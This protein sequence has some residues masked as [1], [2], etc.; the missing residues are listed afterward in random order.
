MKKIFALILLL[1]GLVM[2]QVQTPLLP[3]DA[4]YKTSPYMMYNDNGTAKY[5]VPSFKH[6]T[7]YS[8]YLAI[9]DTLS[10]DTIQVA[11]SDTTTVDSV[12]VT[13]SDT[14]KFNFNRQ[15]LNGFISLADSNDSATDTLQIFHRSPFTNKLTS[16][17]VALK[18]MLTGNL[19]SDN[20]VI[21]PGQG[22]EK[23][24]KINI[25]YPGE[26]YITWKTKSGKA[27]RRIKTSFLGIGY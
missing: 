11:D 25:E 10:I 18:E 22:K 14:V 1:S 20:T 19:V 21:I 9:A 4:N 17:M 3:Q 8:Q 5:Y 7:L 13:I 26:V 15:Y 27:T 6:D 16:S 2:A 23:I 24:Y 12:I